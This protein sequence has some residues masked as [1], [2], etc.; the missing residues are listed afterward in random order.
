MP[1]NTFDVIIVLFYLALVLYIGYYSMK[2]ISGFKDYTVAGR[3]MPMALIFATLAATLAGGG[4]TIGRVAFVYETGLVIF[5]A[6]F[7][8]VFSQILIGQF[9]APRVRNLGNV[10]TVGDV[11]WIFLWALGEIGVRYLFFL[12]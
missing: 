11:F 3:S 5:L 2:R 7:G 8:V 12:I 10:Y 4:A 6:V 9:V 1:V